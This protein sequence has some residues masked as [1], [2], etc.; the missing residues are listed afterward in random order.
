[1]NRNGDIYYTELSHLDPISSTF[2]LRSSASFLRQDTEGAAMT[3]DTYTAQLAILKLF[4]RSSVTFSAKYKFSDF[5]EIHPIFLV[6]RQDNSIGLLSTYVYKN[7]FGVKGIGL[8]LAAG[9]SHNESSID[10]YTYD[11]L[12][13]SA[14]VSYSF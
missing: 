10:F 3:S 2:F 6:S 1:M 7:A 13:V 14:G 5:D 11:S 4:K 12:L 9:Y 8:A